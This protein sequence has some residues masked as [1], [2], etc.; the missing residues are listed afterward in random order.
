MNNN[1][2]STP[3]GRGVETN[4]VEML[5]SR[6]YD[7]GRILYYVIITHSSQEKTYKTYPFSILFYSTVY[8]RSGRK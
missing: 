6:G 5:S 3:W 2:T 1:N 7:T 4:I 8:R